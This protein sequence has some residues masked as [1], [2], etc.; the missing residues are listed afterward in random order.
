MTKYY[1]PYFL[2]YGGIHFLAGLAFWVA[3]SLTKLFLIT[4]LAPDGAAL[5]GFASALAGLGFMGV[6][7]VTEA[8]HQK[9]VIGL[10]IVGN[11]LNLAVHVQNVLRGYSPSSLIWLAAPSVFGMIVVLIFIRKGISE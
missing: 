11:L 4:P 7:F 2:F 5:M 10:S 6:A 9:R 3:P 8:A 1:K